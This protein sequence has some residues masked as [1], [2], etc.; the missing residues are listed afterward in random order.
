MPR[1]DQSLHLTDDQVQ[2][3]CQ[4]VKPALLDLCMSKR[5]LETVRPCLSIMSSIRPD[6]FLPPLL[7]K[8]ST[9]LET[10]TEPHKFTAAVK[11]LGSV[12]RI[13]VR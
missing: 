9:S 13:L 6:M 1:T 4:I 8:L 7:D 5:Y 12:A 2:Q 3:F 10:L 11:C